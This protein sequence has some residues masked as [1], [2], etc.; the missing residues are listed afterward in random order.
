MLKV[1]PITESSLRHTY[2]YGSEDVEMELGTAEEL[3]DSVQ[4]VFEQEPNCR[5]IVVGVD[6]NDC[7]GAEACQEAGLRRVVEVETRDGRVL[8]LMVA[9]PRHIATKNTN[10]NGLELS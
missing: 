1:I 10:I 8:E 3:R 2:P 6:I 7:Q 4:S 5:R 9:E